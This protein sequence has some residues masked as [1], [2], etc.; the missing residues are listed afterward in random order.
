MHFLRLNRAK[1]DFV[2][3]PKRKDFEHRFTGASRFSRLYMA[4]STH[5][6]C[7]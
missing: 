1:N 6:R 3:R 2:L 7:Q 4:V 5:T